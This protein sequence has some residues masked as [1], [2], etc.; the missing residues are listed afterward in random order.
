MHP[1]LRAITAVH[2]TQVHLAITDPAAL[3]YA[4]DNGMPS[5]DPRARTL[6]GPLK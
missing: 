3:A 1:G 2:T 4:M 5:R 6:H